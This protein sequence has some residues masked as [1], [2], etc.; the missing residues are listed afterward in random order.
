M[1]RPLLALLLSLALAA[2]AAAEEGLPAP[3]GYGEGLGLIEEGARLILRRLMA[4][5]EPMMRD[6]AGLIDDLG[7]YHPPERLPNGDIIIRRK[8][9]LVPPPPAPGGGETEL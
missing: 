4:D 3:D 6:L 8:V 7:A 1:P 5:M 2:P 9:P